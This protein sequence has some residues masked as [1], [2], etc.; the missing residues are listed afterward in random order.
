MTTPATY[1]KVRQAAEILG[2]VPN[3]VRAWGA[4]GKIPEYRHPLN[5]YRLYKRRDL[6]QVVRRL[7]RSLVNRAVKARKS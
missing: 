3:T 7:E 2:V 6:E 5:G 4:A 1:V